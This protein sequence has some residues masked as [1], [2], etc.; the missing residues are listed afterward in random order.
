MAW[1]KGEGVESKLELAQNQVLGPES[2]LILLVAP[3]WCRARPWR[4]AGVAS[5][6]SFFPGR[7]ARV[8]MR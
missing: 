5:A 8:R 2:A 7:G 4:D 6:R 3:L 1:G